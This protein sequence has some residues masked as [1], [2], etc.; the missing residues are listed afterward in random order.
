[1]LD[2][3][4]SKAFLHCCLNKGVSVSERETEREREGGEGRGREREKKRVYLCLNFNLKAVN[5]TDNAYHKRCFK[6]K[7]REGDVNKI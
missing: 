4:S 2:S 6:L 3:I 1:M 5:R 7:I